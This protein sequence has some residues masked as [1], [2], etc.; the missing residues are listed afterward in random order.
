MFLFIDTIAD[1]CIA[2]LHYDSRIHDSI[3]WA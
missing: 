3:E 2:L 1:P